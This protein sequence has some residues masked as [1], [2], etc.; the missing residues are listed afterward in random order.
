MITKDQKLTVRSLEHEGF[1]QG[2]H[3]TSTTHVLDEI[4]ALFARRRAETEKASIERIKPV[5]AHIEH[6]T[7]IAPNV[8]KRW[9]EMQARHQG[10]EPT[11]AGPIFYIA[12]GLG[13]MLAE[14]Y[15]LAPSLD[16]LNVTDPLEQRIVAFVIGIVSAVLLHFAWET[17]Q[18]NRFSLAKVLIS[19]V[20]GAGALVALVALGIL[21]GHQNAF[22]ATL[23]DNPL[24]QF[25][26]EFPLLATAFFVF[27]AVGFPLA[28]AFGLTFSL[29]D[30]H[31][32]REY[33]D[34]KLRA[35][36]VPSHLIQSKKQ[37]E[38]EREKSVHD[39]KSLLEEE[40]QWQQ[41]YLT[42]YERGKAIGAKQA[43]KWVVWAKA[44]TGALLAL[45]LVGCLASGFPALLAI[46]VAVFA[47]AYAYF[48]RQRIHPSPE[49]YFDL[50]NVR[51]D[52]VDEEPEPR[53][54]NSR[55]RSLPEAES[56]LH[57]GD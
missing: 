33:R 1:Y 55:T 6:L 49:E 56:A 31:D 13:A 36:S 52:A 22:A 40:K 28:A 17:F 42:H 8:E 14:A 44:A 19:R 35:E 18:E 51:F 29:R 16:L 26:H 46:P 32:W 45:G 20:A 24:G 30:I 34:A 48:R 57:E 15:M 54:F 47:A 43:P 21:R 3:G 53:A 11:I 2:A 4:R 38:A 39:L 41:A 5:E 23:T 12:A 50:Q 7:Q 27:L 10:H 25:L 9:A 37:L